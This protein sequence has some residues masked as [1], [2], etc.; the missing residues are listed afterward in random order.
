MGALLVL[1]LVFA[2]GFAAAYLF[3]LLLNLVFTG[4]NALRGRQALPLLTALQRTIIS[5]AVG[6]LVLIWAVYMMSTAPLLN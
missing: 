6:G 3:L 5:A 1:P 2:A 4:L